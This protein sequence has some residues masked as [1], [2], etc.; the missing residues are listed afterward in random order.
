MKRNRKLGKK[1]AESGKK[2][3]ESEKKI[4]ELG[5]KITQSGKQIAESGKKI[6]PLGTL[7]S[8]TP[9]QNLNPSPPINPNTF[10][11]ATKP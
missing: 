11:Q 4:A 1:I 3:A 2:I 6:V 10:P 7:K 5:K 9:Y 8:Q